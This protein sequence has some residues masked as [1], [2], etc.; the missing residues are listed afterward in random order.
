MDSSRKTVSEAQMRIEWQEIQAAKKN[1]AQFRPLYDRYY[2]SIFKFII[3]RT[4]EEAQAADLCSKVFLK[5][6][7]RL[8]S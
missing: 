5:A 4:G 1:P 6:M 2:E 7:Q 8:D 3:R